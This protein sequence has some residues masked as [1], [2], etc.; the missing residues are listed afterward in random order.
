MLAAQPA[1][2]TSSGRRR[3]RSIPTIIAPRA[4]PR[5]PVSA[6]SCDPIQS[7]PSG[8]P[9]QSTRLPT[10]MIPT[11]RIA[12]SELS[13]C[14]PRR[15][16]SSE[17]EPARAALEG[18]AEQV[19]GRREDDRRASAPGSTACGQL[20]AAGRSRAPARPPP[21]ARPAPCCAT[22]SRR[23]APGSRARG[24]ASMPSAS[25]API[26]VMPCVP[27]TKK[28]AIRM[29]DR[30]QHDQLDQR[31]GPPG[32]GRRSRRPRCASRGGRRRGARALPEAGSDA[33]P[34]W[35]R[36]SGRRWRRLRAACAYAPGEATTVDAW[37]VSGSRLSAAPL[38]SWTAGGD[39]DPP[40]AHQHPDEAEV[41]VA[42]ART[43]SRARR[44][45]RSRSAPT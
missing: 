13:T 42:S 43:C 9:T 17:A 5:E 44:C 39:P 14:R 26:I 45:P 28:P 33:C 12:L 32:S 8:T 27:W 36:V 38:K 40:P 37:R 35:R 41:S 31:K 23:S 10:N 4:T 19:E 24:P 11:S 18:L 25:P 22:C 7:Q 1:E 34:A 16:R 3:S 2:A 6:W 30:Q 15:R 21:R 20:P 29:H